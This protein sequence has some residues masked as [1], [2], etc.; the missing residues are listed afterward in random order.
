MQTDFALFAPLD[1]QE[2][3]DIAYD[4]VA[5]DKESM[6]R[7]FA[8]IAAEHATW[9]PFEFIEAIYAGSFIALDDRVK[10]MIRAEVNRLQ[11]EKRNRR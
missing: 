2:R 3:D 4:A 11:A 8:T 6:D 7:I 1:A 9:T 10:G 5:D